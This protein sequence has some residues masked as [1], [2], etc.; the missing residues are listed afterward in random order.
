M[1]DSSHS[2]FEPGVAP[3]GAC[4]PI[5]RALWQEELSAEHVPDW[6]CPGCGAATLTMVKDSFHTIVDRR[7]VEGREDESW[8]HEFT[9][10]RF[11]CL[12][13]CS[14]PN[15]HES[16]AVAGNHDVTQAHDQFGGRLY[17]TA[18]PKSIIPPPP[19]ILIPGMCPDD[20]RDEV[21]AAFSLFWNDYAA[22]LNRVRNALELLLNNLGAKRG[23][24]TT[25]TPKPGSLP[26]AAGAAPPKKKL[27]SL[28]LHQRI[29][30][31]AKDKPK[32][33]EICD[34]MMA[35]KHLGNAG[36]HPGTMVTIDDVFDGFD[37]L[38]R[39]LQDMYSEHPGELARAVQQ[40]NKRGGP[41]KKG[42]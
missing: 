18:K 2:R 29:E 11:V 16:C 3:P 30:R 9:T 35:V 17:A 28:T 27:F 34:R 19:M 33:I 36:S 25:K 40:I 22:S 5:V 14:K 7:T 15:C 10:G 42:V 1:V 12:L 38:E 8:E 39:V 26:P 6:P 4:M 24:M 37:I 13:E 21:V 31:L 41:R 23:I 32:L 20:V